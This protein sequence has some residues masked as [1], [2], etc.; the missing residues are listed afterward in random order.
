M[1]DIERLFAKPDEFKI[2]D[3]K[4]KYKLFN[5]TFLFV[6][7]RKLIVV[8]TNETGDIV[9]VSLFGD[10]MGGSEQ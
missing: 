9:R 2:G 1:M 8:K 3:I 7:E 4:E 6:C 10:K 5:D